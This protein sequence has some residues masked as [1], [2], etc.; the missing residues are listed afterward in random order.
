MRN[1]NRGTDLP[2][3]PFKLIDEEPIVSE[4]D[5]EEWDEALKKLEADTPDGRAMALAEID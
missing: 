5:W 1:A 2:L 4:M 3:I